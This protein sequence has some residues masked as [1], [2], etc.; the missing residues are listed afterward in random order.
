MA[1]GHP[2]K[3]ISTSPRVG[4]PSARS[5]ARPTSRG[6]ARRPVPARWSGAERVNETH[7][8]RRPD[9][10]SAPARAPLPQPRPRGSAGGAA[11]QEAAGQLPVAHMGGQR[12]ERRPQAGHTL[13]A[14]HPPDRG[15]QSPDGLSVRGDQVAETCE[16]GETSRPSARSSRD[17]RGGRS[18][19][20]CL[21][22]NGSLHGMSRGAKRPRPPREAEAR[23]A[24]EPPEP[25]RERR[26]RRL[27]ACE[28]A[29]Q[30]TARRRG[31][32]TGA[33]EPI[34]G[35]T[36]R[37][38]TLIFG[39]SGPSPRRRRCAGSGPSFQQE[40]VVAEAHRACPRPSAG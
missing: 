7:A 10:P 38:C 14:F 26:V 17:H 5:P 37:T 19:A 8:R 11:G 23:P 28:Y 40:I 1:R 6:G 31:S 13:H 18:P 35:A 25:R 32:P 12:D 27:Y 36:Q 34:G 29:A 22:D 30:P 2:K 24:R 9:A 20:P 4:G 16:I 33:R 15:R 21:A 3:G 39:N